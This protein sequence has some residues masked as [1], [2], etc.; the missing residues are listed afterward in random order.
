MLLNL[1][2]LAVLLTTLFLVWGGVHLLARSRMGE[3]EIGCR[4]P[5]VDA[6]GNTV[7]C[8]DGSPC[9]S[10]EECSTEPS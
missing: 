9:E 5:V 7:C 4:G 6:E 1:A 3:R 2:A 10:A 8:Q